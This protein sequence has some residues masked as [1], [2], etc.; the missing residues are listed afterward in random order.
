MT[1]DRPADPATCT[2]PDVPDNVLT[3]TQPRWPCRACGTVLVATRLPEN[4]LNVL[5]LY[6]PADAP[7]QCDNLHCRRDH[8]GEVA[9]ATNHTPHPVHPGTV[10][11]ASERSYITPPD[12][13]AVILWD[14]TTAIT[15]EDHTTV[16]TFDSPMLR[17]VTIARLRALADLIDH[18]QRTHDLTAH[19]CSQ[20]PPLADY[21]LDRTCPACH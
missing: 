6:L 21:R 8:E 3:W 5:P 7:S 4:A 9:Y 20:R 1:T 15:V 14:G 11:Y 19:D 10:L 18:G 12:Q 13:P 16:L 2:H 17:A